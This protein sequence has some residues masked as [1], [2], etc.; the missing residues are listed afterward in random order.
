MLLLT[1]L[2]LLEHFLI[3]GHALFTCLRA[4]VLGPVLGSSP[5][6][7][8]TAW[9]KLVFIFFFP[10]DGKFMGSPTVG[11]QPILIKPPEETASADFR[12]KKRNRNCCPCLVF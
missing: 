5:H 2:L 11:K 1:V 9:E 8:S 7:F 4:C 3:A 12:A 6:V 10:Q